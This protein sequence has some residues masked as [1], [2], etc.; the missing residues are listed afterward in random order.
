M[1]GTQL[2]HRPKWPLHTT[3]GQAAHL[4]RPHFSNYSSLCQCSPRKDKDQN[5]CLP[6]TMLGAWKVV[7]TTPGLHQARPASHSR[8]PSIG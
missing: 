7:A 5:T 4:W 8:L 6:I 3:L 2:V 1:Q